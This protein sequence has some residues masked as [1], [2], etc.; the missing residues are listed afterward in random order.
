MAHQAD[1]QEILIEC[2]RIGGTQKVLAVD[3]KTGLEVAFQA[4]AQTGTEE[5][6]KLAALKLRYVAERRH[7]GKT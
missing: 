4:P 5:I 7:E 3:A 6:R 1:G 2:V